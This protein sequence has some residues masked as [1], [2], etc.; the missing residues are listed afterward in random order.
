MEPFRYHVF[1]CDQRKPEG[2][3][4]CSA[5]GSG[6]VIDALRREVARQGLIDAVQI[7]VCGSLGLC[8][9]GPNMVVYPDGIW[10]G[11]VTLAD[12]A[13]I[14]E[15]HF[16]NDTV[17]ERLART[18][19]SELRAEMLLNRTR[20]Q[21]AMRR[22]E[23]AGMLP[24]E[25]FTTIRAFQESRAVL[26]AIELDLFSAIGDGATAAET[27]QEAA[28]DSRATEILLNALVALG[29]LAKNGDRFSNTELSSKYLVAGAR[30]DWRTALLH[31]VNMWE[32]WSTLTE[33]VRRGT[34]AAAAAAPEVRSPQTEAFIA[35][36]DRIA[37]E[38]APLVVQA[39]GAMGVRRMLD[40]GGGSAA[41]SIAFARASSELRAEVL[42]Q[43]AVVPIAR[44]HIEAAGVQDRVTT[45]PGDL[46]TDALGEG[47]D[48]ILVSAICH[49]LDMD[50][51]RHLVRRCHD[52]LSVG[53]RIVIQDFILDASKTGPKSGAMFALNML[54]GTERGNSYSEAEYSGWMA[55]AGFS[56]VRHQRL[57][58]PSGLMMGIKVQ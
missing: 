41:Y 34:S 8:E 53:G 42:D 52:A 39:V 24:E 27:A 45:R 25:L 54:V 51:N 13:E 46:K 2:A 26:T 17:V 32:K 5:R 14:V 58:G 31:T 55:G 23:E 37:A 6:S 38:R 40:I 1:A 57:P 15:S 56:N 29:L 16:K 4:A 22:R 35:A 48:L 49:M 28:T 47:Y 30:H 9:R 21:G 36:M 44:R 20:M 3:P 19:P 10:Y 7:T 12:V 11:G 43:P 18:D 33:S 50:E